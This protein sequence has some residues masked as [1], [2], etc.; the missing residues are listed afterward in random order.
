MR[1][2]EVLWALRSSLKAP[3]RLAVEEI[4]CCHAERSEAS[5]DTVP[6]SAALG[7]S[8]EEPWAAS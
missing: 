2:P 3:K 7:F 6:P 8:D 4:L 5:R 1:V